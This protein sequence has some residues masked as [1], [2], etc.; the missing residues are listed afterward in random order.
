VIIVLALVL[1]LVLERIWAVKRMEI[2]ADMEFTHSLLVPIRSTLQTVEHEDEPEHED[3]L[4]T[5]PLSS[6]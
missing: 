1:V 5:P 3:D 4:N 2:M 6:P